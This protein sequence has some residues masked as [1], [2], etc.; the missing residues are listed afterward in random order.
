MIILV[1]E[2]GFP[3]PVGSDYVGSLTYLSLERISAS[4]VLEAHSR[5]T[6]RDIKGPAAFGGPKE[7]MN[8]KSK[9]SSNV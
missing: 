6:F 1:L 5:N 8:E 3:D 4:W 2:Q 7:R 9:E